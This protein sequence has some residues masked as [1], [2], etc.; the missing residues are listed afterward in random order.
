[1]ADG[2][3]RRPGES[4]GR[5][6]QHTHLLLGLLWPFVRR[7]WLAATSSFVA[8]L[9]VVGTLLV[10]PRLLMSAI[11]DSLV[12]RHTPLLPY[13]LAIAGLGVVRAAVGLW[14]RLQMGRLSLRIDQDLRVAVFQH[15]LTL[16]FADF[17][18]LQTGQIVSRANSDVGVLRQFLDFAPIMA[19]NVITFVASLWIMLTI[20]V[21]LTLVVAAVVPLVVVTSLLMRRG[22]V[23]V[24]FL[25]QA[26]AAQAATLVEENVA[27]A[28]VVRS[29]AAE[30]R[31][32]GQ[33]DDVVARLRWTSERLIRTRADYVPLLQTWPRV[34]I[35]VALLY[36]GLL[37]G[38][39]VTVGGIV[40]SMTYLT[41]LSSSFLLLSYVLSLANQAEASA[42]RIR[43]LLDLAPSVATKPGALAL[44]QPRGDVSFVGVRFGYGDARSV[45]ADFDL[46]VSPG[47]TVAIVGG[48]GSGKSTV[49]RLLNRFYDVTDGAVRIDGVDIRD[50]TLTSLREHV[51]VVPDEPVIFSASLRDNIA[52]ARPDATDAQVRAAADDAMVTEFADD[53]PDGL[54]TVVGE[55]G[56]SLSGGQRQRVAL[57]RALLVNPRILVLDDATSA[58]DVQTELAI[59]ERLRDT[60]DHRTTILL[61]HRQSTVSLAD[62][63]VHLDGGRVASI[64][65][66]ATVDGVVA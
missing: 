16:S 14:Q 56:Q 33:Y 28:A 32:M 38:H 10:G 7:H 11:D 13:V 29:F 45:L 27:G 3:S 66:R 39:G 53:L 41:M 5:A 51:F 42:R 30:S 24:A 46:H 35:A 23:P 36:G 61:A 25:A 37:A 34:G 40:A 54:A 22:I 8:G 18:T 48:V 58:L 49:A 17:D 6:R 65:H 4:P 59:H 20:D 15:L 9:L 60:L 47:E 12:R 52:Y 26:R 43:E 57:A 2:H 62:R 21:Q 50:V 19:L 64:D 63:V 44:A 1:V 31:Q 55:R